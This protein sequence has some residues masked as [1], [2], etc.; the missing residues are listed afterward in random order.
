MKGWI[1]MKKAR[2]HVKIKKQIWGIRILKLEGEKIKGVKHEESSTLINKKGEKGCK[3]NSKQN[4]WKWRKMWKLGRKVEY[5]WK[6][7]K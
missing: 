6:K 4:V 2:M 5:R 3:W 1:L 7:W